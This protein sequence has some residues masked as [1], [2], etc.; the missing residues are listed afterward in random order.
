MSSASTIPLFLRLPTEL[1]PTGKLANGVQ[2]S[3]ERDP[4]EDIETHHS[5]AFDTL[6][7]KAI[8]FWR[9]SN[10]RHRHRRLRRKLNWKSSCSSQCQWV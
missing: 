8:A 1:P 5:D 7:R 10:Q 9:F 6:Q 4:T 2:T 3:L